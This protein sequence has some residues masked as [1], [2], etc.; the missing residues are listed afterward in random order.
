MLLQNWINHDYN[1]D[2]SCLLYGDPKLTKSYSALLY[3]NHY[4]RLQTNNPSTE[5]FR[6]VKLF[7]PLQ[8]L[9]LYITIEIF[10]VL[11]QHQ[12]SLIL[13]VKKYAI[14]SF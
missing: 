1:N 11:F 6:V 14:V 5:T 3:T 13:T 8:L 2:N 4:P 10:L 9:M 12:F 7:T